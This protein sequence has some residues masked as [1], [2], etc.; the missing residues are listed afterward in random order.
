MGVLFVE[1]IELEHGVLL[2][3][4]TGSSVG[5]PIVE[6]DDDDE[7]VGQTE[8]AANVTEI[9]DESSHVDHRPTAKNNKNRR[10]QNNKRTRNGANQL[11]RESIGLRTFSIL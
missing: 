7:E 1:N 8:L 11:S 9:T 2:A 10:R 6:E 5:L 4:S 3:S